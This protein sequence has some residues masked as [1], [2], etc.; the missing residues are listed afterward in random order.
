MKSQRL[1]LELPTWRNF[2]LCAGSTPPVENPPKDTGTGSTGDE[3]QGST[4][5]SGSET[6]NPDGR[7]R[8]LEEERDRHYRARQTAEAEL[9]ELREFKTKTE[10]AQLTESEKAK[11]DAEAAQKRSAELE[12]TNRRLAI[13]NA[14]LAQNSVKWHDP[15]AALKLVDLSE[16]KVHDGE[17]T[18][19][20]VLTKAIEK[21]A[22]DSPWLVNTDASKDEKK[23]DPPPKSG[24]PPKG[25]K[26]D[27]NKIDPVKLAEKY[28]A[29]QGHIR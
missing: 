20:D 26:P 19:L 2:S 12:A 13:H 3:Q 9:N 7:I 10:Q 6:K 21:L 15:A 29:L 14:F 23:Q 8:A 24:Q 27:P 1:R 11:A 16:V 5:E 17:V 28:P 25:D 22:A 4:G 18:N